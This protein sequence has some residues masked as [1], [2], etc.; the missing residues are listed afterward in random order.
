MSE[1]NRQVLAEHRARTKQNVQAH[2]TK[3]F[4]NQLTRMRAILRQLPRSA[5]KQELYSE[6]QDFQIAK[7]VANT[8]RTPAGKRQATKLGLPVEEVDRILEEARTA[9][10]EQP[11]QP[12]YNLRPTIKKTRAGVM[13]RSEY[14]KSFR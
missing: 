7:L 10:Q 3:A 12:G 8:P 5:K 1:A 9:V 11:R 4:T 14:A 2:A 6:L 13:P